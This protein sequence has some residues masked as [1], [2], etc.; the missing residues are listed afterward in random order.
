[1]FPSRGDYIPLKGWLFRSHSGAGRNVILVH[2]WNADRLGLEY[3]AC[4]VAH[5]LVGHGYDV[6]LFDL[7][8]CEESGGERFTLGNTECRDVLGAY[9]F[10]RDGTAGSGY[11]VGQMAF[12]GVSMGGA[13]LLRASPEMKDVE[14]I[15]VDSAF[16]ELRPLL[17]E[18]LP[19]RTSLPTFLNG[20]ILAAARVCYQ[21]EPNLRPIEQVQSQP[22]R[23]FLFFHGATD[24]IIPPEHSRRLREASVH[25]ASDLVVVP[26]A[27]H[28]KNYD[29]D[30]AA[31]MQRIYQFFDTQLVVWGL[32]HVTTRGEQR[33]QIVMAG[34]AITEA[35]RRTT[36]ADPH[37]RPQRL[38]S[39]T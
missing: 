18:K 2:G 10:M 31:Y 11:D 7:R 17:E 5:D 36:E 30:P 38:Q 25:P 1:M 32:T 4:D 9:D 22:E 34:A 8:A 33:I 35:P 24:T 39:Q 28:G 20:P 14:A 16:A 6:L 3:P 13:A 23:A 21:L 29:T 27:D 37:N 15:V 19:G 26:G 12:I